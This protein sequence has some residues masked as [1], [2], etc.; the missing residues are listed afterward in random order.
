MKLSVI[1]LLG[2]GGVERTVEHARETARLVTEMA[3]D[4]LAALTLT[5][6]RARP[7]SA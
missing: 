4:F 5:S 2:A 1:V 3:P 6:F 7:C